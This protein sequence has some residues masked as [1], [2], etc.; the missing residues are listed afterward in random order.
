[1]IPWIA[2]LERLGPPAGTLLL[3]GT[4]ALA[5][6]LLVDLA[7][8]SRGWPVRIRHAAWLAALARLLWLAPLRGVQ[9]PVARTWTT[10]PIPAGGGSPG[11]AGAVAAAGTGPA[12]PG[13]VPWLLAAWVAGAGLLALLLL[14][15]LLLARHAVSRQTRPVPDRVRRILS[16]AARETGLRRQPG[17]RIVT[18]GSRLPAPA[19]IGIVRPVVLLPEAA[20]AW[21]EDVLRSVLVHE[22][23]HVRRR[24]PLLALAAAAARAAWFFHPLAWLAGA[25]L[26][27]TRELLCDEEVVR[28]LD[29]HERYL[30]ALL[31]VAEETARHRRAVAF[32]G[33]AEPAGGLRRRIETMQSRRAVGRWGRPLLV[34]LAAI[35][36]GAPLV[37]GSLAPSPAVAGDEKADK[38]DGPY[39]PGVGGVTEPELIPETKVRPEYPEEAR[40]ARIQ[41]RVIL[42]VVIRKDGTVGDFKVL[43]EPAADLGFAEAA[44]AAVEQWRYRPATKDGKPVPVY[45]V[46]VVNFA[47]DQEEPDQSSQ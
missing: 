45:F 5:A 28:I 35:A 16:R 44:I 39:M 7:A 10:A 36:L 31:Q 25:R 46:V 32:V 37:V 19:L 14:A 33:L 13:M 23:V 21:P 38:G 12:G 8:R 24:D 1:M 27:E 30:A 26:A 43:K 15:R 11:S 20:V 47:P 34:A 6:A 42:Q 22:C 41:G 9:L 17:A 40:K 29:G 4:L 18:E 2:A 3:Q